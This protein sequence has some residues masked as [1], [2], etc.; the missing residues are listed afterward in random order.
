[1]YRICVEYKKSVVIGKNGEAEGIDFRDLTERPHRM[2]FWTAVQNNFGGLS[3]A[4]TAV[5]QK[6]ILG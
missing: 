2:Q 6:V 5:L 3:F 4:H 1:M